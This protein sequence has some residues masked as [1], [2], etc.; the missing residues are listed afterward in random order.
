MELRNLVAALP[1]RRSAIYTFERGNA[2]RHS[3]ADLHAD[4]LRARDC[5]SAWGVQPGTRV[6]IYAPNSYAWLVHDLAL[7]ELG[8]ISVP[9]TDDFAGQVNE[10]LLDKYNIA[11]LLISKT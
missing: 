1:G 5:L 6:G 11:L 8:A 2:R 7:I 4:V 10:A 9:F 3:H